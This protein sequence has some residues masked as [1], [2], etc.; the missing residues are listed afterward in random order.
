MDF[1]SALKHGI[2][3]LRAARIASD[4]LAAELL[5]LHATQRERTFLYSHPEAELTADEANA[6]QTF[7][8]RRISGVPVQHLTR[9]QEFWSLT[10]EVTP[11]V[12][13][14]RPET[15][16]LIEVALDRLA[17]R[18]L[19]AGRA[20]KNDGAG[21][22]IA[23]VGTGSGCIAVALAKELPQAQFIALDVSPA[24]LAVAKR[25]AEKHAVSNSINFVASNLFDQLATVAARYIVPTPGAMSAAVNPQSPVTNNQPPLFDL[26][27]S[28]PPYI[29]RREA[30]SLAREVRDHEPALALFGGEEGY[31]FYA[32]LI[33]QSAAHL[34]PG[35]LLVLELG[36]NSLAAVQPLLDAPVWTNV[37][38]TND[39]AGI[40]RVISAERS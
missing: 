10:F 16:H 8:D 7:L 24:A 6:Y 2:A 21:L 26:I 3:Q 38:V 12:L 9:K 15:E 5:L 40:P 31:E 37:G 19:R 39:L 34:K 11:D 1:R 25:N 23:D 14:P 18:E 20:N 22:A 4:T 29:G 30:P 28:N 27:V 35:G 17:L 32:G 36:H 33:A 13:I